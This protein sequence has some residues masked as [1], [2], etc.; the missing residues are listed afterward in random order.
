MLE[1]LEVDYVGFLSPQQDEGWIQSQ[2]LSGHSH[3]GTSNA[4]DT[5]MNHQDDNASVESEDDDEEDGL[6]INNMTCFIDRDEGDNHYIDGYYTNNEFELLFIVA[7]VGVIA[8]SSPKIPNSSSSSDSSSASF[9]CRF[10]LLYL[11]LL[12]LLRRYCLLSST[13]KACTSIL[14]EQVANRIDWG[15][16]YATNLCGIKNSVLISELRSASF[17]KTASNNVHRKMWNRLGEEWE[18]EAATLIKYGFQF[19]LMETNA[20]LWY[21]VGEYIS[22]SEDC[23]VDP[24]DLISFLLELS[25]HTMG[26]WVILDQ[27][28]KRRDHLRYRND[29][30]Q[31]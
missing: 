18:N 21:I 31:D 5:S 25:F 14:S 2:Y 6:Q 8:A 22:S 9:I 30:S 4:F 11:L 20:Q 3:L 15:L 1:D 29:E 16:H 23:G 7:V 26:K 28:Q 19:L 12:L 17:L 10:E 24:T 13:L 27:V